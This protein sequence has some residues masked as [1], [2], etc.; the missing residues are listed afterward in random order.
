MRETDIEAWLKSGE[1][2]PEPLRDFHDQKD[3]FKAMHEIIQERPG[4][5]IKR[6][7]WIEGQVYVIDIFLWFM[8]RRGWTLQ[9]T[10]RHGKFRDLDADVA[11]Q[12]EKRD[13][14]FMAMF[15]AQRQQ[16][17]ATTNNSAVLPP[18]ENMRATEKVSITKD[19]GPIGGE[20]HTH[21]AFAQIGASRVSGHAHLY[22]SDF[23]HQHYITIRICGSEMGRGLSNDWHFARKEYIEVSL[24]EAQWAT[25]VSSMNV[26]SG[27]PCTLQHLNGQSVPQL[28]APEN[29]ADKFSEEMGDTL[30]EAVQM[31]RKLNADVS[32]SVSGKK[33][34]EELSR[35]IERIIGSISGSAKFVAEQFDEHIERTVE[36]AKVEVNAYV[37]SHVQRAGLEALGVTPIK[38]IGNQAD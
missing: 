3:V 13:A 23:N 8:A 7:T 17:D 11:G 35:S 26:G 18:G 33:K 4:D 34:A 10:R 14:A 32:E 5:L 37:T 30:K 27:V 36:R 25:F 22:D 12:S 38:L 24:S 20:R 16:P 1:Y 6:P 28:P 31:L 15:A 29:K 21:P 19:T 2:L 9:R